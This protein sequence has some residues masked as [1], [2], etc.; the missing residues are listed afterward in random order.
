[1]AV[2][3]SDHP[4]NTYVDFAT[5]AL[6]AA[7]VAARDFAYASL[8]WVTSDDWRQRPKRYPQSKTP[9]ADRETGG[10]SISLPSR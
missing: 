8:R 10:S 4:P 7:S 6:L 1:L 5:G 2:T 9:S 3:S